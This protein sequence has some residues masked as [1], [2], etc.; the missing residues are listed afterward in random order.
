VAVAPRCLRRPSDTSRSRSVPASGR[1]RAAHAELRRPNAQLLA[2]PQ[3]T[4]RH[5]IRP[6]RLVPPCRARSVP[7]AKDRRVSGSLSRGASRRLTL[8]QSSRDG[9][10]PERARRSIMATSKVGV[11]RKWH[12]KVP[13][14]ERGEALPKSDWARKRPY[15]WA[16]RWFGDEGTRYSRSFQTRKA[17][18]MP[19]LSWLANLS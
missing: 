7:G 13:T 1:N 3:R 10:R 4:P 12:G 9:P 11:F 2:R 8:G 16:V 5:E 18:K 19:L 6:A 15:R 17:R 14:D